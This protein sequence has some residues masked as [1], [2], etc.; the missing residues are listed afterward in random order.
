MNT[1]SED[2][3][4]QDTDVL[5][6]GRPRSDLKNQEILDAAVT[7]FLHHGYDGTSMDAVAKC[8]CVSKQTVYSHFTK[9]EA[10]FAAAVAH[11]ISDYFPEAVLEVFGKR[12]IEEELYIIARNF[13]GLLLGGEAMA[14]FRVLVDAAPK[15]NNL[16]EIFWETGPSVMLCHLADFLKH[17]VDRGVLNIDDLME[18]GMMLVMLL[19]GNLHFMLSIGLIKE[20]PVDLLDSHAQKAVDAFLKLYRA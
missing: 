8:A 9:K 1:L 11:K 17:W 18:A 14:M 7:L 16:A 2:I 6:R 10:L 13:A 3:T 12:T 20:V 5:K 15:D 19:K 4:E